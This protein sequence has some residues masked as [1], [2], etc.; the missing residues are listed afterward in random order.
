MKQLLINFLLALC[1]P[2]LGGCTHAAHHH[3]VQSYAKHLGKSGHTQSSTEKIRAVEIE[4]DD[5]V[6]QACKHPESPTSYFISSYTQPAAQS[7]HPFTRC[8][9]GPEHQLFASTSRLILFGV[10]RI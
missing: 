4:E 8:L 5:D 1:L 6:E 3:T 9:S 10:F 2:L 7:Y